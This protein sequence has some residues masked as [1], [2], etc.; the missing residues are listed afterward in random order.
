MFFGSLGVFFL[1]RKIVKNRWKSGVVHRPTQMIMI[2]R[3]SFLPC[4]LVFSFIF[5]FFPDWW[6]CCSVRTWLQLGPTIE[7]LFYFYSIFGIFN[8]INLCWAT[9]WVAYCYFFF[10]LLD[11]WTESRRNDTT[12]NAIVSKNL[13]WSTR[14]NISTLHFAV[15]CLSRVGVHFQV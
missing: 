10:A 8:L 1:S 15:L 14:Y 3:W 4:L 7:F 6:I 9:A 13:A 2:R 12:Q 5:I 11:S